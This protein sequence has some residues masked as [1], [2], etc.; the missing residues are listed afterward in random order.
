M[1]IQSLPEYLK[2]ELRKGQY[3]AVYAAGPR[4]VVSK[5]LGDNRGCRP[6]LFG[7][8]MSWTDTV[9]AGLDRGNYAAWS[10]L[11]FRLWLCSTVK[12]KILLARID[13]EIS[14]TALPMRKHWCDFGPELDVQRL[15]RAVRGVADDVGLVNFTDAELRKK[16]E[17]DHAAAKSKRVQA[18]RRGMVF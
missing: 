1:K 9:T 12:A 3:C 5:R 4:E 16:L 10:G 18:L 8:T 13:D 14:Q 7:L 2:A 6:V 15:E 17:A 11:L